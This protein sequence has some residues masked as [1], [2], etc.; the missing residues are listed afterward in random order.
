MNFLSIITYAA[1]LVVVR[2]LVGVVIGVVDFFPLGDEVDSHAVRQ[3]WLGYLFGVVFD[4]LVVALF[5][6]RLAIS[7][8]RLRWGDV[9]LIFISQELIGFAAAFAIDGNSSFSP[10]LLLDY[11]FISMAIFA[12]VVVGHWMRIRADRSQGIN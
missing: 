9:M 3:Y 2:F 4:C 12:G 5:F 8:G 11:V 6:L 10:L 7:K 1:L